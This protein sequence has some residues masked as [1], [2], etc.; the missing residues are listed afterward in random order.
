[1][2]GCTLS[3]QLDSPAAA[4]R[5][6]GHGFSREL[7]S[8]GAFSFCLF[9]LDE[10]RKARGSVRRDR[11]VC[12]RIVR[13]TTGRARSHW[14]GGL[15]PHPALWHRAELPATRLES[16]ARRSGHRR[17]LLDYRWPA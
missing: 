2:I 15:V 14:S 11:C 4:A 1:A 3:C 12:L 10:Y 13:V 17:L 5:L 7:A 9:E 16:A 8:S 6:V